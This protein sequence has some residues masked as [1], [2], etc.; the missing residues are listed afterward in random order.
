MSDQ[1]LIILKD[2]QF[3]LR[4][5]S[6]TALGDQQEI[7]DQLCGNSG[8]S[9]CGSPTGTVSVE[10][11]PI[12][13]LMGEKVSSVSCKFWNGVISAKGQSQRRYVAVEVP[14]F[15]VNCVWGRVDITTNNMLIGIGLIRG[16]QNELK[17]AEKDMHE[18]LQEGIWLP[19]FSMD[20]ATAKEWITNRVLGKPGRHALK[21]T[22]TAN[23]LIPT[24]GRTIIAAS[25]TRREHEKAYRSSGQNT[26]DDKYR[27]GSFMNLGTDFAMDQSRCVF[28]KKA[29]PLT[30]QEFRAAE[31]RRREHRDRYGEVHPYAPPF[32]NINNE[33][34][35]CLGGDKNKIESVI[36]RAVSTEQD[37]A[38]ELLRV[39]MNSPCSNHWTSPATNKICALDINKIPIRASLTTDYFL[40]YAERVDRTL[41]NPETLTMVLGRKF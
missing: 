24:P 29:L 31:E 27:I 8:H 21:E 25:Y 5:Y 26:A 23:I 18:R 30:Q 14:F 16:S 37:I 36:N 2:G 28:N 38:Q 7:I 19:G 1:K 10:L 40:E 3:V 39:F 17:D 34:S 13:Y 15:P 35:L 6:E 33:G 22:E 32:P 9:H 20:K 11:S 41:T 12:G 4:Q